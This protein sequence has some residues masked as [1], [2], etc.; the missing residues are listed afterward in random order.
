MDL[1]LLF[2]GPGAAILRGDEPCASYRL[3]RS[4]GLIPCLL[5]KAAVLCIMSVLVAT[6]Y[7]CGDCV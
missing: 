5:N 2:G 6:S 3:D 1:S 7:F 4:W